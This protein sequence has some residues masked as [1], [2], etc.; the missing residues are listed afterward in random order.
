MNLV[1]IHPTLVDRWRELFQRVAPAGYWARPTLMGFLAVLAFVGFTTITRP[2]QTSFTG[3]SPA[4]LSAGVTAQ[5]EALE[6][7]VCGGQVTAINGTTWV[8]AGRTIQVSAT[9]VIDKDLQVGDEVVIIGALTEKGA[10]VATHILHAQTTA[11]FEFVGV[12]RSIATTTWTL[13]GLTVNVNANTTIAPALTMG[14]RVRVVGVVLP[15]GTWLANAITLAPKPVG[16]VDTSAVVQ[17][18]S[19]TQLTLLDGQVIDLR[20]VKIEGEFQPASVIILQACPGLD[21]VLRPASI[22]I[23]QRLQVLTTA[24]ATPANG[25]KVTICHYPPGNPGNRHTITVGAAAVNAHVANHGDTVG[26]CPSEKPGK[27][28]DK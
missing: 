20:T 22:R 6:V 25:A 15:D 27:G 8:V 7:F 28:K 21:G 1:H 14:Q 13:S 26:A 12:V 17:S 5:G 24:T 4:E 10:V 19:G 23:V 2:A 16:C 11:T 3:P 18:I 9:T